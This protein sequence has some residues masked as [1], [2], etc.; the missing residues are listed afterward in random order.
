[1]R[2]AEAK[3]KVE[4]T[5]A[6]LLKQMVDDRAVSEK[7]IIDLLERLVAVIA[8]TGCGEKSDTH[9]LFQE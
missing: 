2:I 5:Y 7:R 9:W 4:M 1:V 6:T 3:S 8:A